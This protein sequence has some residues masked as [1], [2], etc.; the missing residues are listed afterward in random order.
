MGNSC[1]FKAR[2]YFSLEAFTQSKI[3][4]EYYN[5]YNNIIN[6]DKVITHIDI[7]NNEKS[8][9]FSNNY[10]IIFIISIWIYPQLEINEVL[11]DLRVCSKSNLN[12]VH[13]HN[14]KQLPF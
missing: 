1:Y 13:V 4:I 6:N 2:I 3:I 14:F 9:G 7:R 11:I 12:P 10:L 8:Q 5:I